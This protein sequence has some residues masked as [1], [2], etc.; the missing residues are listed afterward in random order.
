[1]TMGH[2]GQCGVRP[3]VDAGASA[4]RARCRGGVKAIAKLWRNLAMGLH[5]HC[6]LTEREP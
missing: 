3:A 6:R 2:G 1:M 5:G 4:M